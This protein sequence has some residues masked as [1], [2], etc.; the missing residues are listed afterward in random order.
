LQPP[1]ANVREE[2]HGW[3]WWCFPREAQAPLRLPSVGNIVLHSVY[4]I[5][6]GQYGWAVGDGGTI[7][8]ST[9]GGM[10]WN[11]Q[12]SGTQENLG[13]VFFAA[14]GQRGWTAGEDST[15]LNTTDSGKTWNK[16]PSGTQAQIKLSSLFFTA[17][18]QLGWAVGEGGTIRS[19]DAG[20]T[21]H[22]QISDTQAH[23]SFVFFIADGQRGW[24]LGD[25]AILSTT[26]G[27]RSWS[28]RT[29]NKLPSFY[30]MFFTADGQRGWAVGDGGL[31]LNTTDGGKTWSSQQPSGPQDRFYSVF[32]T[33]DS[34]H[35]W[36]VGD[37]GAI[38][39]TA[40][41]GK[42]WNPQISGTQ[43][44]L[45]SVFFTGD[46][47]H[48]WA[49]G[50]GGA[51]LS[52]TDG[53]KT[54]FPQT[55]GARSFLT[56]MSFTADGQRGWAVGDGGMILNTT[57]SGKTWN[58]QTSSTRAMLNSV[59]FA[60][61]GRRGWIAG[62][63]GAILSTI[64]GGKRWNLRPRRTQE[65]YNAVFFN[66]DGR[67]GWA[68]G[69]FVFLR[70]SDGGETWNPATTRPTDRLFFSVFFADDGEHGWTVADGGAILST[71]DGGKNWNEQ[72]S[73]R[74][75][76]LKSVLF[77][78]DGQRGWT[79]GREGTILGTIDSGRTWIA[80]PNGTTEE[81]N[82]VF[83]TANGQ[84]G[85]AVGGGGAILSTTDG[86]TNWN[87]QISDTPEV[88][89]SVFFAADG[90]SGWIA[91][92]A[93]TILTTPDGGKT[94]NRI[95]LYRRA[96]APVSFLLL[97]FT[98]IP[99]AFATRKP[100]SPRVESESIASIY[101]SD[102]ALS[103]EDAAGT[104]LGAVAA[105][106]ASYIEN[107]KTQAPLVIG[108]TG[109]WG[110]G[111][112][113]LMG[114]L[115]DHLRAKGFQTA[116]FNAWH[117]QSEEH[118]FASL[119]TSLRSKA[120]PKWWTTRGLYVRWRL[121]L[122]RGE[123]MWLRLL[124]G[125]AGAIFICTVLTQL[126][127][128]SERIAWT[129]LEKVLGALM[130]PAALLP[131]LAAWKVFS[132]FGVEPTKLVDLLRGP[133]AARAQAAT[134]LRE[135]FAQ[136]FGEVTRALQPKALTLFIDDLDRCRPDQMFVMLEAINFLASSGSCYI[137]LGMEQQVIL[138]CLEKKLQEEDLRDLTTATPGVSRAQL[139][140]EKL[141]Q[142]RLFVAPLAS[143]EMKALYNSLARR[144]TKG[145]QSVETDWDRLK[146]R[147]PR[148]AK[149]TA[150]IVAVLLL[151]GN[152]GLGAWWV[153][154]QVATRLQWTSSEK[155]KPPAWLSEVQV[156]GTLNNTNVA[157]RVEPKTAKTEEASPSVAPTQPPVIPS[158]SPNPT[159]TPHEAKLAIVTPGQ[160]ASPNW[161]GFAAAA[162]ALLLI[163][164][165][166]KHVMAIRDLTMIDDSETFTRTLNEFTPCIEAACKTPRAVKQLI[167]RI[168]L[169][170]MLLRHWTTSDNAAV[171]EER[172]KKQEA[173]IVIFGI[174][175]KLCPEQVREALKHP[176]T[177][178]LRLE[179]IEPEFDFAEFNDRANQA[180]R[181]LAGTEMREDFDRLV[182]SIEI[183]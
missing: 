69:P 73:S 175:E 68:V 182:R 152:I 105:G 9:D 148:F 129:G 33:A 110:S 170:A 161:E 159:Q 54:W 150:K 13:S 109:P 107:P 92:G 131:V 166:A 1:Y 101:V 40:N 116:W 157:L 134:S 91:G 117:Q 86:G 146:S 46:S 126:D 2:L 97:A 160:K 71:T 89:N 171:V 174:L 74:K 123:R 6:S 127:L 85:W 95:T 15:I 41:G 23:L 153:G 5:A 141:V 113:S 111:K 3:K 181:T 84:H 172:L 50:S 144:S 108:I 149:A 158:A 45:Q 139:W 118:L 10:T 119:L 43:E 142:L 135:Q 75:Q 72:T 20:K 44:R 58:A 21:W 143:E 176:T 121:L 115:R 168:R 140:L 103:A 17:D 132:A 61:D 55:R 25:G 156:A 163:A 56:S 42:T 167:N 154:R 52:T 27:G 51:I 130:L 16:Q 164:L 79:V 88:L 32:F 120:L 64:D 100:P 145:Q 99:L 59:F 35:G 37:R 47:H 34:Q 125:L 22:E 106:L 62:A 36:T 180:I 133:S 4:F 82:S 162:A 14:D 65:T 38:L 67:H 178:G 31:I 66:A 81:L 53:G 19:T 24:A 112:S 60:A 11:K 102:A 83:F 165:G 90:Q 138:R 173:N 7:L 155:P 87:A 49:V 29:N 124:L 57:D 104:Q 30:S 137:V 80:Q 70:T 18:G 94:W 147:L 26:D 63:N 98:I 169:Y 93:G 39:S 28:Q 151:I 77:T 12:P 177:P 48:G 183:E 122:E 76:V 78:A 136:E 114:V 96:P 179:L 128:N 8:N